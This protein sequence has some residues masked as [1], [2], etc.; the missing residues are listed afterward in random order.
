V[1]RWWSLPFLVPSFAALLFASVAAYQGLVVMPGLRWAASPNAIS[2]VV[3]RAATRG[4]EQTIEL[5]RGEPLS[6]LSLDVNGAAAG[7]A[8]HYEFA[9]EDGSQ[10]YAGTAQAPPLGAPLLVVVPRSE[11]SKAGEWTLTLRGS[12]GGEI[13]RYPFAVQ[14][15]NRGD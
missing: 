1:R 13:A 9:P 8:L 2:P 10:R 3:L 4:E 12:D 6:V 7:S 5:R 15:I 11:L 14:F